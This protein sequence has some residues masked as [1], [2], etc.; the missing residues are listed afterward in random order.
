MILGWL[1]AHSER[2]GP[3]GL[4]NAVNGSVG[5]VTSRHHTGHH[6]GPAIVTSHNGRYLVLPR[7][8]LVIVFMDNLCRLSEPGFKW[9]VQLIKFNP[10][11]LNEIP[12][13]YRFDSDV[14]VA[15]SPKCENS[16][17]MKQTCSSSGM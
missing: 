16:A 11:N 3:V 1:F 5:T 7:L 13:K 10:Q 15:C 12:V 8:L 6:G 2:N 17:S 9:F 4:V 14:Y